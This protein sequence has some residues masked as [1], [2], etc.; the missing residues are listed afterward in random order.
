MFPFRFP[1]IPAD[2]QDRAYTK[3]ALITILVLAAVLRFSYL[4]ELQ[5]NPLPVMVSQSNIFDQYNYLHMA[6]DILKN[7]WLGSEHPGHSPVYSYLIAA[8]YSI[9]G[10]DMNYVFIFQI[11]Y[12]V[13]AVYLF[14]RCTALLFHNKNLGLL[15]AFV[16]ANY[17]PLIFYECA[18]LRE[19]LI[20][21][22]NL[23]AL[24]FFLLALRKG[25]TKNY[26]LAGAATGLSFITRAG[27]LPFFVLGTMLCS[28]GSWKKRWQRF[29]F[30]LF[31]ML[32]I[33]APLTVRN[34]A[35][36][37]NALT[38]T[39]GPTLFWLGNSYDSPGIGLTY[40][41]TQKTLTA[42]TQGRILKT[43][44]VLWREIKNHPQEYRE[45]FA[46]KFKMLFNGYEI[47]ANISYDLFKENSVILKLAFFNFILISPLAL[48]GLVL[49]FRKYENIELLYV[50]IFSLTAFVFIFH[51]QGRYRV[52]FLPFYI[53]AASYAMFW[54]WDMF[55]T[56]ASSPL[57]GAVVI[58]FPVFLFTYPDAGIIKRYFDGGIRAGDYSNMAGAYLFRVENGK[59]QGAAKTQDLEKAL[60]N[61]DKALPHLADQDKVAV[62]IT[63]AMVYRDLRLRVHAAASLNDALK[64][65]PDNPIA[66]K[67]YQRLLNEAL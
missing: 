4:I 59:V 11:L 15:A 36:G 57:L 41:P 49:F 23:V 5:A 46:R 7:S 51:I 8:I 62:Y 56:K 53:I 44:E 33:I 43:V 48:L 58:L 66:R 31:G 12:G 50:F 29:A 61:Y 21:Y 3:P 38:E 37:F 67:E 9:F 25:K 47:P 32:I 64:I 34:Y 14:Y 55:R 26:V 40:T 18:L 65:D 16:A 19:S 1:A 42:E 45:L 27:V 28:K 35:S 24:Y 22:T 52:A 30:V 60:A 13:L 20:A 39:S 10:A 17:S 6:A 2:E 54:F 63:R